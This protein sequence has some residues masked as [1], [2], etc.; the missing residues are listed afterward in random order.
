VQHIYPDKVPLYNDGRLLDTWTVGDLLAPHTSKPHNP[1]IAGAFFRSG[2]IEAWGRGIERIA[3]ACKS[4][5]KPEPF[6]RLRPNEVMIGF[7]TDVGIVENVVENVVENIVENVGAN[8]AQTKILELIR[9]NPKI[10][11]KAIGQKIGIAPR[12][13]QVHIQALKA[14]GL[15]KRVGAAKGGYWRVNPPE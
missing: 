8:A 7:D 1:L 14:S 15:I 5:G 12:N 2:Q 10:T 11:A 9:G 3:T 6:F 13:A 4:W